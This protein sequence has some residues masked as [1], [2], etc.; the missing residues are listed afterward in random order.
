MSS[1]AHSQTIGDGIDVWRPFMLLAMLVACGALLGFPIYF[2]VKDKQRRGDKI[3]VPGLIGAAL[4]GVLGVVAV[5][6]IVP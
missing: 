6:L 2:F 4:V 3:S 5:W 1:G